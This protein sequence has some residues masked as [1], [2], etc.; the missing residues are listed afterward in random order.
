M[1]WVVWITVLPHAH[2]PAM[3]E[4]FKAKLLALLEEQERRHKVELEE[5]FRKGGEHMR[6]SILR[7]AQSPVPTPKVVAAEFRSTSTSSAQMVGVAHRAPRGSVGK[8]I[9]TVLAEH[10][11]LMVPQLEE[12]VLQIDAEIAK[13]SIGNELRR[14]EGTK[15]KRDRPGGYRWF[16]IDQQVDQEGGE[17]TPQ[18]S[19]SELLS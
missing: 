15:Y 6:D 19:A 11:G 2:R 17:P 5:A 7:A 4:E 8:A 18:T 1:L 13:K 16:L 3:Q 12:A 10:H 14:M 9:D